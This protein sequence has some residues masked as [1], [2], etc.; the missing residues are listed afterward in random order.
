VQGEKQLLPHPHKFYA[1]KKFLL[2]GQF[3]LKKWGLKVSHLGDSANK[4]EILSTYISS[5]GTLQ[6]SVGKMQLLAHQP[7]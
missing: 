3:S 7:S 5:V 6:L 4:I 2:P 1:V